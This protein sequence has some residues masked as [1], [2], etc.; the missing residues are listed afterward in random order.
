MK[1]RDE[2]KMKW[3]PGRESKL[4]GG[5]SKRKV[6]FKRLI[7]DRGFRFIHGFPELYAVLLDGPCQD[8][9]PARGHGRS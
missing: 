8:A 2:K 9:G 4:I 6:T 1:E 5:G 7:E 3:Q